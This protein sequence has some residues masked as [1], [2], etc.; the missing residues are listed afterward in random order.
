MGSLGP[1]VI[2]EQKINL[3]NSAIQE[4][5]ENPTQ[6]LLASY[7]KNAG[8]ERVLSKEGTRIH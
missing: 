2:V 5:T 7:D 4:N 1:A 3:I 8:G 6:L